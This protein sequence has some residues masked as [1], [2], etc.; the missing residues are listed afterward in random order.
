MKVVLATVGSLGD[1]HPFIALARA[2]RSLDIDPLIAAAENYRDKVERSGV[3]FAPVRPSFEELEERLGL[4]RPALIQRA[5][6]RPDFMFRELVLP[7]LR[8]SFDDLMAA[9][10]GAELFVTSTLAFSARLA[11]EQRGVPWWGVVLQPFMFAS[12]HDPPVIPGAAW[13]APVLRRLGPRVSAGVL[14]LLGRLL[15]PSLAPLSAFR[16]E[17]GLPPTRGH[18]LFEGQYSS[19]GAIALYS[20]ILG[21]VQPDYPRPTSIV[22]FASYDSEDGTPPVLD[23][24]LAGFLESGPAPLVF[25]LGSAVVLSPGEFF[26]ASVHA[27]RVLGRRAVLL[28][29]E[30]EPARVGR[31]AGRAWADRAAADLY[32]T[33]YAPFSLL[34]PRA[35]LIVHHGGIGTFAEALK[36]GRPQLIVPHFVDQLDNAA[37]AVRL[38]VARTIASRRY[39]PRLAAGTLAAMLADP[40]LAHAAAAARV[41]V[42]GED[43]A[44]SAARLIAAWL[45][46]D[47]PLSA[48]DRLELP[49]PPVEHRTTERTS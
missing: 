17:L 8:T 9:S 40:R 45:R 25:T 2:L 10:E 38:G 42:Q 13:L 49:R 19:L 11:A 44:A 20:Q 32:V 43:G 12:A 16:A 33:R 30:H 15:A 47:V 3:S 6:D 29:G 46:R 1:L 36:A 21:P 14:A 27:A 23:P 18:P 41:R 34:F 26:E 7:S 24:A 28:V 35:E 48:R 31:A 22:G 4:D 5:I 37:R 39:R